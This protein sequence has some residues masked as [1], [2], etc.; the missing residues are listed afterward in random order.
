M[1]GEKKRIFF[2]AIE[3]N[4]IPVVRGSIVSDENE[5]YDRIVEMTKEYAKRCN[6][7]DY[8]SSRVEYIA[9]YKKI[10][11]LLYSDGRVEESVQIREKGFVQTITSIMDNKK[12]VIIGI[13]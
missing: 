7:N 3:V 13:Y 11:E 1:D 12:N 10:K 8:I 2:F 6:V 4:Q 9:D 5:F